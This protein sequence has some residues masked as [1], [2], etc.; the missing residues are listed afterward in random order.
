MKVLVVGAG[1]SVDYDYIRS[2]DGVIV[3]VDRILKSLLAE[4]IE[5]D[6]CVTYEKGFANS[7]ELVIDRCFVIFFENIPKIRTKFIHSPSSHPDI[8]QN[9]I[10]D[11]RD[12]SIFEPKLFRAVNNVGLFGFLFACDE[13]KADKIHLIGFDH[14]KT[15]DPNRVI[16][17]QWFREVFFELRNGFYSDREVFYIDE[18]I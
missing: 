1:P 17:C 16:K 11:G 4:Q 2:F 9:L 12:V 13:L 10:K 3:C 5:P 18:R 6:Y 14:L 15:D 7:S 8:V